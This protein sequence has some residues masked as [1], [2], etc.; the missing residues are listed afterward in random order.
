METYEAHRRLVGLWVA[1]QE[2]VV[3]LDGENDELRRCWCSALRQD[4]GV[5]GEE[6]EVSAPCGPRSTRSQ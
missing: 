1:A 6:D 4:V 3:E 5:F 2:D